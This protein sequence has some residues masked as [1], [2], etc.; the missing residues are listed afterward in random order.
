MTEHFRA[1]IADPGQA[2]TAA[3]RPPSTASSKSCSTRS[4][5]SPATTSASRTTCQKDKILESAMTGK[6]VKA[7]CGKKWTAGPR[8][9]EVPGLPD[10]QRDLRKDEAGLT[11]ELIGG[12]GARRRGRPSIERHRR[13]RLAVDRRDDGSP[14]PSRNASIGSSRITAAW[15]SRARSV[16]ACAEVALVDDAVRDRA[17][18]AAP[19]VG[20]LVGGRRAARPAGA[21][22]RPARSPRGRCRWRRGVRTRVL[23]AADRGLRRPTSWPPDT[24]VAGGRPSARRAC[25][26]C[27]RPGRP[28]R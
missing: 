18:P 25:R 3:E 27:R 21:V 8:P 24:H 11:L 7:L 26:P 9:G 13:S 15:C 19:R 12:L 10:L 23:A 22:A 6:P 17:A 1:S 20:P 2:R 14:R 5:S 16:P 4:R 28:S